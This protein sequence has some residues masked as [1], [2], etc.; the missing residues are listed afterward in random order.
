MFTTLKAWGGR[1]KTILDIAVAYGLEQMRYQYAHTQRMLEESKI[2]SDKPFGW[3]FSAL[4]G[5]FEDP[6]QEANKKKAVKTKEKKQQVDKKKLLEKSLRE[7]EKTYY[8]AIGEVCDELIAADP[9][10]LAS[11]VETLRSHI[12]VAPMVRAGK[13]PADIYKD[14]WS[15]GLVRKKIQEANPTAFVRVLHN[16]VQIEQVKKQLKGL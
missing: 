13:S 12:S 11:I 4:K 15:S 7:L 3:F 5:N 2:K 16:P 14:T 6:A 10:L 8:D 1:E 9:N